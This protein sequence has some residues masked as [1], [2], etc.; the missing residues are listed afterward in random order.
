MTVYTPCL[1]FGC[2]WTVSVRVYRTLQP[3]RQ[4]PQPVSIRR[5]MSS[6]PPRRRDR[7]TSCFR[8]GKWAVVH[9]KLT[10]HEHST[11]WKG[12]ERAESVCV[13]AIN[14]KGQR[15]KHFFWHLDKVSPLIKF[16]IQHHFLWWFRRKAHMSRATT[17]P[18]GFV[19]FASRNCSRHPCRTPLGCTHEQGCRQVSDFF[20][21]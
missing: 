18:A 11:R 16:K 5:E 1:L 19:F 2:S 3:V 6:H 14:N 4:R 13:C 7:K 9:L 17:F 10:V 20:Q 12:S 21:S 8:R 15:L